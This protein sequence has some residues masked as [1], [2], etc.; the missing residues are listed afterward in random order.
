MDVTKI[1]QTLFGFVDAALQSALVTGMTKVMLGL[2]ALFGTMWLIHFTLRNMQWLYRGMNVAFEDVAKEIAKMAFI[3]GCAFNLQWYVQTIVPFVT[4]F[5]NWMGGI[6]SGQEGTQTN[7]I[8]SLIVVYVSNLK[9]LIGAMNFDIFN[10]S[11][12]NIWLGIQGVVFYVL[13]GIPFLLAAVATL[14]VLKVLST[15]IVA[16]GLLFIAFL[17]FDQTKQYFWGWVAAI[18]GFMLAQILISVVLA[19]EIGFINTVMI[20]NGV[21]DTSLEGNLTIL[22]VFCTFTALVIELPGQAASI[23][24]GGP[25]GGGMVSR[26]SGFGA[27]KGMTR[28][29]AAGIS[30]LRRGRNNIK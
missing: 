21:M 10:A 6:L 24:G 1:S 25:S 28:G 9:A 11:F 19:I 23:M 17:L 5:P 27:A 16:V 29:V 4:G 7:Q 8:D 30:R 13:G 22:I 20:K 2:G 18:A 26:I 3:A 15:A 14:Y 12:T